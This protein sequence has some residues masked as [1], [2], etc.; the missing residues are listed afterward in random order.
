MAWYG[1]GS[2]AFVSL[3]E[4]GDGWRDCQQDDHR[5]ICPVDSNGVFKAL[6]II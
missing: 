1:I 5:S 6:G 4:V 2:E 3:P